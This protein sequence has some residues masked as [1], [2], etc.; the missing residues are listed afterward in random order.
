MAVLGVVL[1]VT[2]IVS[3]HLVS[4]SVAAQLDSLVPAPLQGLD[5]ALTRKMDLSKR[6]TI[7]RFAKR[8][9]LMS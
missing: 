9:V 3:V 2:S 6:Q 4:A 1:G 8:G 7:L 5:L